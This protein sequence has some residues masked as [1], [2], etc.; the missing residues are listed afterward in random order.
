MTEQLI[1]AMAKIGLKLAVAESLTGGLLCD[2]FVSVAGASKVFSGG[3]VSYDTALKHR[4]LGVDAALLHEKGPVDA[5]V[6]KQMAL[7]VRH[8]CSA[9]IGIATTGVAGPDPDPQTGQTAGTVWVGVSSK[10]GEYAVKLLLSGDRDVIRRATVQ[11][12][13]QELRKEINKLESK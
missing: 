6:A 12:A 3:I 11:A 8:A 4:L 5:E 9:D 1:E 2:A 10:L 7:G 13:C